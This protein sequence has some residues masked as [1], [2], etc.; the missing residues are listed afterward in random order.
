MLETS[1]NGKG[2]GGIGGISSRSEDEIFSDAATEFVDS[3]VNSGNEERLE[4]VREPATDVEKGAKYLNVGQS[5]KDGG[6][7][8]K[9]LVDLNIY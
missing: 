5:F 6:F 4:D 9:F 8:G 3:G 1:N 7:A 2:L